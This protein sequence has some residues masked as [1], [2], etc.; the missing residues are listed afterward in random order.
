MGSTRVFAAL[1]MKL[2]KSNKM[3]LAWFIARKNA[4]PVM[5]AIL[6]G[7]EKLNGEGDAVIPAGMWLIPL[8]F[9]DDIRQDPDIMRISAP[10][11]LIDR[12]SDIIK[13][14]RLP[15]SQYHPENYPNP[16]L[17]KHFRVLQMVALDEP[18][19]GDDAQVDDRTIPRYKGIRRRAGELVLDWKT[20]LDAC[21]QKWTSEHGHALVT[22]EAKRPAPSADDSPQKKA[23]TSKG[24]VGDEEMKQRWEDQTISKLT[25]PVLKDFL[26]DKGLPTSGKKPDLVARVEQFYT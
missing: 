6:A 5:A 24:N 17:Q 3:A 2:R 18:L 20:E 14:L 22:K 15:G 12:M 9:A 23:K 10:D 8:P 4:V 21:A 25:I 26:A 16:D 7:D 11:E 13:A 19:D 1:R